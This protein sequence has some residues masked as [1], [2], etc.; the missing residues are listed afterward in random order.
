MNRARVFESVDRMLSPNGLAELM[1]GA[2]ESVERTPL[3]A[4][5]YSGNMLERVRARRGDSASNFVLKRFSIERDWVMRLTHDT[6]VR[7]AALYRCGVYARMP[8]EVM[9]PVVAAAP[10]GSEWATLM[11][12]VAESLVPSGSELVALETVRR[13]LDHLAAIHARFM[14]DDSL[15]DPALGLS[16]L[17]DFV[18]ILSPD[19]ARREIAEGRTHPVLEWVARGWAALETEAAPDVLRVI[20][21][22]QADPSP[23]LDRLAVLPHTLLHGDYKF[24]NLGALPDGRT[25]ILDWQDAAYGPPLL[26]IGYFLAVNSARL[27]LSKEAAI[28][29]YRD[30]L[31]ARGH[32]FSDDEW[33]QMLDVCLMA[34]GALRL[35][36]QKSLAAGSDLEWWGE[37]VL[38]AGDG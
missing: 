30:S 16:S 15:R 5:H 13:F 1:G 4:A 3:G 35:L 18:V 36:W 27:P 31:A 20:N 6:Q 9:V 37:H 24:A 21:R 14:A 22:M 23:L 34:G 32:A 10:D 28:Q 19:T 25:A 11:A 26:D 12:D 2:V 7:E 33:M 8:D 17:V 29:H 38:R